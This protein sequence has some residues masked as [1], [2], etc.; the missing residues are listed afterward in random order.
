MAL[1]RIGCSTSGFCVRMMYHLVVLWNTSSRWIWNG[2]FLACIRKAFFINR[3]EH[4]RWFFG[5]NQKGECFK[6]K[7]LSL[8]IISRFDY[9]NKYTTNQL[10]HGFYLLRGY[11]SVAQ[12]I[13]FSDNSLFYKV[14]KDFSRPRMTNTS[15]FYM[16][17]NSIIPWRHF[18]DFERPKRW[19]Y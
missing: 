18:P 19:Q 15:S 1:A 7:N 11:L 3:D 8:E 12:I 4:F 6:V 9:Q 2:K 13:I 10:L 5:Q 16:I 17:K 14:H